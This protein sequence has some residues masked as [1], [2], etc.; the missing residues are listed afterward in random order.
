MKKKESL[1]VFIMGII[2]VAVIFMGFTYNKNRKEELLNNNNYETQSQSDSFNERKKE[3]E[4]KKK[5]EFLGAFEENRNANT[6][7]DFMQYVAYN[8]Q[9]TTVSFYGNIET[10]TAWAVQTMEVIAQERSIK[11]LETHFVPA[12]SFEIEEKVDLLTESNPDIVFFTIPNKEDDYV[13]VE[14]AAIEVFRTYDSIKEALPE[15]L[16]VVLTPTP[17][18]EINEADEEVAI[19]Q[20]YVDEIVEVASENKVALFNLHN[21]VL[22]KASAADTS[23]TTF[24]NEENQLSET[25][26]QTIKDIFISHVKEATVDTSKAYHATGNKMDAE[27][28]VPEEESSSEEVIEEESF[29]EEIIEEEIVEEE[30][31]EEPIE[32]VEPESEEPVWEE[33]VYE[34]PESTWTP[35]A[36]STRP[37]ASSSTPNPPA[38]SESESKEESVEPEPEPEQE[39][40]PETEQESKPESSPPIIE[41]LPDVPKNPYE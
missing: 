12:E 16:I 38:S 10:D 8:K 34:E 1:L 40:K 18:V 30:S 35:P 4:E 21:D 23:V 14:D 24:Y 7:A 6:V 17:I 32:W 13:D 39:S 11:D 29:E 37:P 15:S 41:S 2:T 26:I 5:A 22:E 33:P 3:T 36:S 27:S 19:H 28:I 20:M 9:N 31:I 25:G